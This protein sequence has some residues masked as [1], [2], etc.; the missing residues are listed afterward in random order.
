MA[1]MLQRYSDLYDYEPQ[2]S[3]STPPELDYDSSESFFTSC[4]VNESNFWLQMHFSEK[5]LLINAISFRSV[6][7]EIFDPACNPVSVK[8]EIWVENNSDEGLEGH[9]EA[10]PRKKMP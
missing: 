6:D 3:Y 1:A 7:Q 8:V 9:E 10:Q 4:I 5:K 2:F